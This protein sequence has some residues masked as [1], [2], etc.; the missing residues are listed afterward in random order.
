[1]LDPVSQPYVRESTRSGLFLSV[2]VNVAR[3]PVQTERSDNH[4]DFLVAMVLLTLDQLIT[5]AATDRS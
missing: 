4:D 1:M 5:T 2:T 3:S